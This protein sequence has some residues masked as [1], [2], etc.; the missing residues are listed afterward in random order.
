M[1]D[2]PAGFL[3]PGLATGEELQCELHQ[4]HEVVHARVFRTFD[5]AD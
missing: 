5:D 4:T 2:P 1:L 3:D